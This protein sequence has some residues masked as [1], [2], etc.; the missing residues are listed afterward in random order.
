MSAVAT[1]LAESLKWAPVTAPISH[2]GPAPMLQPL[3]KVHCC[4]QYYQ[5]DFPGIIS[6]KNQYKATPPNSTVVAPRVIGSISLPGAGSKDCPPP[7]HTLP[8]AAA[9]ESGD[10][11]PGSGA[12]EVPGLRVG[13]AWLHKGGTAQSAASG[14]CGTGGPGHRSPTAVTAAPAAAPAATA[15][16]MAAAV[17]DG[18]LLTSVLS[19]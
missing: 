19:N 16:A 10:V 5:N 11:G 17:P 4:H 1:L 14:T 18:P 8:A 12:A 6:W 9:G 13:P 15:S 3:Q 7:S 2:P